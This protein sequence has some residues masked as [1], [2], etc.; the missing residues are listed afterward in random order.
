[1]SAYGVA[2]TPGRRAVVAALSVNLMSVL[3]LFLTGAMAVQIGRELKISAASV[4][5]LASLFAIASMAG[6]APLGRQ[7]RRLGVR[8]SLR[9]TSAFSAAAL[10]LACVSPTVWFLGGAMLLAG[11]G[12]SLGQ[13]AG[14]A[15]V[16]AQVNPKRYGLGFAIKQSA[17]PVATTL[18]GLAVPIIALTVGWRAAYFVAA[19]AALAAMLLIPP[20]QFR[21][22]GRTES[23]VPAKLVRPLWLLAIGMAGAVFAATSI[24]ALGAA[25]GVHVGLSE[26]S[27]GYLVA[28]GGIAGLA[29]RLASG[30]VADRVAFDS[31]RAVALLVLIGGF[32]W[33]AMSW[34][35]PVPFAIGLVVANAFGWGW[36]GLQHLSMA[37]RFPTAT[38]AASGVSQTG[39]AA[40]LLLGPAV[41]GLLVSTAG[42]SWSWLA[43]AAAAF[44]GSAVVWIAARRIP[45]NQA[46]PG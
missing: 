45:Q 19:F 39:V 34:D 10:L 4:G 24:G 40:G 20:D 38:A 35:R 5:I 42:W 15:L 26:A 9:I 43:A 33:L 11:A 32:G 6:S 46:E 36:P 31:L 7:V 13:P 12:N 22:A 41:L 1:M 29:I 23:P 37:R 44:V 18:G 27:A 2:V 30:V 21:S 14:N 8:R 3:P 16:A 25:G 28:V 17:I